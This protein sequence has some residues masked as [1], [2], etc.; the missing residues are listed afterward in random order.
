MIRLVLFGVL[1]ILIARAF[2]RL[3]DSII[4]GATGRGKSVPLQGTHMV[5]DPVCGT[6]VLPDRAIAVVDG[7]SRL[8]FCS[9]ACRDRYRGRATHDR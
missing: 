3:V 4:E 7:P 5:R 8:Y 2:W 1:S 6:F 9:T